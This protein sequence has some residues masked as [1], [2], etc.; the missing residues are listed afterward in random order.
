VNRTDETGC[1]RCGVPLSEKER[2]VCRADPR[3]FHGQLLCF[4]HQRQTSA[5]P[6]IRGPGRLSR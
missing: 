4:E 3:R 1:A 5:C 6:A 2:E